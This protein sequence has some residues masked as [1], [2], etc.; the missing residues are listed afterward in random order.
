MQ[1]ADSWRAF[2]D[3]KAISFSRRTEHRYEGT[4]AT[5]HGM[6]EACS[7]FDPTTSTGRSF[8]RF[9]HH[10]RIYLRTWPA[11]FSSQHQ[12][13]RLAR[14]FADDV[15]MGQVDRWRGGRPNRP[16]TQARSA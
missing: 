11:A 5:V 1:P 12:G 13:T 6:V 9:V 16:R 7:E 3:T 15:T 8:V 4:V 10:G 2:D 14:E